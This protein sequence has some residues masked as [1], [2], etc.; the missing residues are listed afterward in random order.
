M[1]DAR[2]KD[3][4]AVLTPEQQA[5]WKTMQGK[6]FDTKQLQ[7]GFGGFGGQGGGGRPGGG[8]PGAGGAGGRP[9]PAAEGAEKPAE[10]K[11]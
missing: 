4:L 7:R 8:R 3:L 2:D 11:P 9:R 5:E 10:A 1:T 6:E